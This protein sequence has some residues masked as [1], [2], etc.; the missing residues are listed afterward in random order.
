MPAIIRHAIIKG[1][2][3][4][5]TDEFEVRRYNNINHNARTLWSKE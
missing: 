1:I 4:A 3:I 2:K 5:F